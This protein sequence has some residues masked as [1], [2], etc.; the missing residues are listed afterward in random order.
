M[1]EESLRWAT[2][3]RVMQQ[4]R[5]RFVANEARDVREHT[6]EARSRARPERDPAQGSAV[7]DHFV[8]D[9][10]RELAL[11]DRYRYRTKPG[12]AFYAPVKALDALRRGGYLTP[13]EESFLDRAIGTRRLESSLAEID[14]M[15]ESV[16]ERHPEAVLT[17]A[18][19]RPV[20]RPTRSETERRI[21]RLMLRR[22]RQLRAARFQCQRARP[23]VLEIGYTSGGHSLAAFERLG[24]EVTG[25]D[26]F[27]DGA[28]EQN[29]LPGY[30]VHDLAASRAELVVGDINSDEA[31]AGQQFDLV[32]STSVVE[33]LSDPTSALRTCRR[34]I[35]ELGTALHVYEPFFT[36]RGGHSP[37]TLDMPWGHVR[38]SRADLLRYL[39]AQRPNEAE[40]AVPWVGAAL[41]P[42]PEAE[43]LAAI[44][45]VGLRL[46]RWDARRSNPSTVPG[47]IVDECRQIHPG[48]TA[49]DLATIEITFQCHAA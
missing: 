10:G 4:G 44:G 12:W 22:D 14:T 8:T 21:G 46:D 41:F 31:L 18:G 29:P 20:P 38:L 35:G 19:G 37:A 33:H 45:E 42:A 7:V 3:R 24:F 43:L 30:V 49:R 9:D 6:R 47:E 25:I 36:E 17:P 40:V 48:L 16:A 27:Y 34:L 32:F 28:M 2:Y 13:A 39:V 5:F 23:R 11:L 1:S 15:L 26:N